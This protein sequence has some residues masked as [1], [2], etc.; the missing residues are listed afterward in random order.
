MNNLLQQGDFHIFSFNKKIA[1]LELVSKKAN[2][3]DVF[4]ELTESE[5]SERKTTKSEVED[6]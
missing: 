6:E 4:I 3:E 1:L 5:I 2:L